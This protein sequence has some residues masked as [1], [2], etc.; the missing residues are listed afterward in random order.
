MIFSLLAGT[1]CLAFDNSSR[2]VSGVYEWIDG[3]DGIM[4]IDPKD[5]SYD[6]IEEY[7]AKSLPKFNREPF[8]KMINDALK[9]CDYRE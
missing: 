8:L 6:L 7:M 9:G 4:C 3:V 1:P 5:I 2:K